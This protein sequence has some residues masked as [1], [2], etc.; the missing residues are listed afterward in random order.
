MNTSP[1]VN[2]QMQCDDTWRSALQ[3]VCDVRLIPAV[4][5]DVAEKAPRLMEAISLGGLPV[6]EILLRSDAGLGAISLLRE[7]HPEALVGAGTVRNVADARRAMEA[8][9]Q[10][11]VSPAASQ[12]LI[13]V[14]RECGLLVIPGAC[15]PTEIDGAIE[16]GAH[17]V[18][19]FPAEALGGVGYLKAVC[20]ALRDVRLVP[21]GG[22]RLDNLRDYLQVPQVVACGG[23][24][25]VEPELLREERFDR[26]EALV[27]EA[28]AAV[29]EV[30]ADG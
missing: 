24:W 2:G 11:I 22:I 21:T 7:T 14:C 4:Q 5:I 10:F 17:L 13:K 18:K 26:V 20:A 3:H 25:M 16:A 29:A 9:A 12:S 6:V 28:V 8:G 19:L 23:T 27:R 15:T 1:G 30:P